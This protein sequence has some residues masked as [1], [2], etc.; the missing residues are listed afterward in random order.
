VSAYPTQVILPPTQGLYLDH[1]TALPWR[2]GRTAAAIRGLIASRTEP[3]LPAIG[4]VMAAAGVQPEASH[5]LVEAMTTGQEL[6]PDA[7]SR[8]GWAV[9]EPA[10]P[11]PTGAV[12][13]L[14]DPG[15]MPEPTPPSAFTEEQRRANLA[16]LGGLFREMTSRGKAAS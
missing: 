1:L 7:A 3:H 5:L 4:V 16:R 15:G 8:T 12:A 9:G 11:L 10:R 6:V 14:P 13:A 2:D